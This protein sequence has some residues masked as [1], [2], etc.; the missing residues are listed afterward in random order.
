[1]LTLMLCILVLFSMVYSNVYVRKL[2]YYLSYFYIKRL[3][4]QNSTKQPRTKL[5]SRYFKC[6]F[7]VI[8]TYYNLDSHIPR[9]HSTLDEKKNTFLNL[10]CQL[11]F[12]FFHSRSPSARGSHVFDKNQFRKYN[13]FLSNNRIFSKISLKY[14]VGAYYPSGYTFHQRPEVPVQKE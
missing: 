5:I 11:L 1:M 3:I 14:Y 4:L 7:E 12:F 13:F 8:Q 10:E 6:Y 2:Y 9:W